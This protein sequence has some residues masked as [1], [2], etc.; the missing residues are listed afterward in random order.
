VAPISWLDRAAHVDLQQE[1]IRRWEWL[2]GDS[3][4]R[5]HGARLTGYRPPDSMHRCREVPIV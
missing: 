3:W 5:Y 1:E 4:V 2:A